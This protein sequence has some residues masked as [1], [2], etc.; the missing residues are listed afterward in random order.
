MQPLLEAS[1]AKRRREDTAI[2]E[3]QFKEEWRMTRERCPWRDV[4]PFQVGGGRPRMTGGVDGKSRRNR[5][6]KSESTRAC[7][8]DTRTG[9]PLRQRAE[10]SETGEG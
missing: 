3:G 4:L 10:G 5:S 2:Q 8:E 6:P 9:A 7:S 1:V